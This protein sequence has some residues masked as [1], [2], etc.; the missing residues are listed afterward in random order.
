[1][2]DISDAHVFPVALLQY[3]FIIFVI[4]TGKLKI[5]TFFLNHKIFLYHWLHFIRLYFRYFLFNLILLIT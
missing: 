1:M 3:R 2:Y 4:N 5:Y